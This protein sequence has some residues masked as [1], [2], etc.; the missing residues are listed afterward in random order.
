MPPPSP[1]SRLR[2]KELARRLAK[3][4]VGPLDGRLAD[5][6]RRI[7]HVRATVEQRSDGL[8]YATVHGRHALAAYA[9]AVAAY[10]RAATETTSLLGVE[11]R[12]IDERLRGCQESAGAA[13][14][15]ADRSARASEEALAAARSTGE[16]GY[17]DRLAQAA[18]L[19][20]ERLDGA[21]ADLINHANGHRGF[22]A[23]ANLWFNPP[24]HT[25]LSDGAARLSV[26]NER[27]VEFPFAMAA[28]G[29]LETSARILDI[30]GG[31]STF[32]LSAASLGFS[33]L[34]ID[35]RPLGYEHPNLERFQGR[36][37]D[38]DGG[39]SETFDAVFLISTI[40]HIG[41]GAYDQEPYGGA[42]VG[43]GADRRLIE[44]V[45]TLLAPGGI[46][47]LTTPIG[48]RGTDALE[49]T[50]D[51]DALDA[52]LAGFDRLEH[53]VAKRTDA[54]TWVSGVRPGV[55]ERGVAMVVATPAPA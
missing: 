49:R 11:L 30:G 4:A 8:E 29:R 12:R 36:F 21:L 24:A 19:P 48:E 43:A 22:A 47:V 10:A 14:E 2:L 53:R 51:E 6:I 35:P 3:P 38:W 45:T 39:S 31:E 23:Q 9:D 46:L 5:L 1:S 33:V 50:Y 18:D 42:T 7:E 52:L 15:S 27:I 55:G 32:A 44:R 54:L 41:V 40:E 37:E 25:Q 13:A 17:R 28:L 26:V 16:A 20:L 34:A